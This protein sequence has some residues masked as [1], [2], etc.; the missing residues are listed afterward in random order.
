[1][2]FCG[3]ILQISTLKNI[4]ENSI[5]TSLSFDETNFK[6]L[7]KTK[8]LEK[9]LGPFHTLKTFGAVFTSFLKFP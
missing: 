3:E 5:T 8:G 1:L 2:V 4:K 6:I 9:F 7:R